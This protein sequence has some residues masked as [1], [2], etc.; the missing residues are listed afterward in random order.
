LDSSRSPICHFT[1]KT[2]TF[3]FCYLFQTWRGLKRNYNLLPRS[4][5][6]C[7]EKQEECHIPECCPIYWVSC[8]KF[9]M[10]R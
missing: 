4:L 9:R 1:Q 3:N 10:M 7:H 8:L 2:I 6:P 5:V